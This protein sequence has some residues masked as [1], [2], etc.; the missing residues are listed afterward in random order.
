MRGTIGNAHAGRR[1]DLSTR[2]KISNQL[3]SFVSLSLFFTRGALGFANHG[4]KVTI[5]AFVFL[6]H[7]FTLFNRGFFRLAFALAWRV[8]DASM[9]FARA[10]ETPSRLAMR[11]ATV[12]KPGCLLECFM[13]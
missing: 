11:R 13:A 9:S 12:T 2:G 3:E 5:H 4:K 7:Y 8:A 10:S 1:N 6:D